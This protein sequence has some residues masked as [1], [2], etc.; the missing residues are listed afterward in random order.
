VGDED[1]PTE[2]IM[3][4]LSCQFFHSLDDFGSEMEAAELLNEFVIV[5]FLVGVGNDFVRINNKILLFF[6]FFGNRLLF[7]R[8]FLFTQL[9]FFHELFCLFLG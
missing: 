5:N 8:L 1:A 7:H 4:S 3:G 9:L 2:E 6:P